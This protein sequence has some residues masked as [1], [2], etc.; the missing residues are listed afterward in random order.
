MYL[1]ERGG[2]GG[3]MCYVEP[4]ERVMKKFETDAMVT[5]TLNQ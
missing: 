5:Y 3:H 4:Y 1:E 2:A